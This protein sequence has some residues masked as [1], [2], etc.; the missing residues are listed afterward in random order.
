[1][2]GIGLATASMYS[3]SRR[4]STHPPARQTFW[5]F[6]PI[7]VSTVAVTPHASLNDFKS[8]LSSG[9]V[10]RGVKESSH[11]MHGSLTVLQLEL[12]D[13]HAVSG[14][15]RFYCVERISFLQDVWGCV[16]IT[17]GSTAAELVVG[18]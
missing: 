12:C 6:P 15:N 5:L 10:A 13:G 2:R 18:S 7:V 17:L 1:M 11:L 16:S 4:A 8:V 14:G 9:K 3:I